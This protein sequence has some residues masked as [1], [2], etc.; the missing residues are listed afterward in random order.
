[1][2]ETGG[3]AKSVKRRRMMTKKKIQP[4]GNVR[5]LMSKRAPKE[6]AA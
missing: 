3:K 4:T 2:V 6:V 1:M 5:G